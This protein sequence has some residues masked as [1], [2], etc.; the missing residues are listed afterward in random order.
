LVIVTEGRLALADEAGTVESLYAG[1][2][3]G[4]VEVVAGRGRAFSL[5][6]VEPSAIATLDREALERLFEQFPLIAVSFVGELG[7][8]LKWRNDLLREVMLARAQGLRAERLARL[9][10]RRRLALRRRRYASLRRAG[11]LVMR[12]LFV[13]P[14]RRVSFWM[15]AGVTLALF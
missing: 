15:F 10:E 5:K 1:D 13:E 8:E 2:S 9:L 7:R 6:A 4:D 12:L 14:A 11:N 3:V